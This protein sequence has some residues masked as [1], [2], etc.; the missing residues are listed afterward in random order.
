MPEGVQPYYLRQTQP[1]AVQTERQRHN[2]ALY[3]VGE[4][5]MFLLM[6]HIEDFNDGLVVRCPACWTSQGKIAE[7]FGQESKRRCLTCFGT[8]FAGPHGGVKARIV[9]PTIF[10]DTD[11]GESFDRR[12][13]VHSDD[14]DME[15]TVDFRVR[16]GDYAFR[17]DG[18]RWF[19]RVPQ[20][21]TVRTG[22]DQPSQR[23]AAVGYNHARATVEDPSSVAYD[24]PPAGKE[25]SQLT[26]IL[27]VTSNYPVDFSS[28][29]FAD[30]PLL[31]VEDWE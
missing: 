23:M 30:A 14:V 21:L 13:V 5:C 12:G 25:S 4:W 28:V 27:N 1:W 7:A 9:R 6:W 31:P 3:A 8:T 2:Q 11:E 16:T 15:S 26:T 20:R 18:T 19:L 17:Q 22:F 24:I 10:D 29:E